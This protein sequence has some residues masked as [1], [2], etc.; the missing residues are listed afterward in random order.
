[1]CENIYLYTMY[2]ATD[3]VIVVKDKITLIIFYK[4]T[5]RINFLKLFIINIITAFISLDTEFL[6]NLK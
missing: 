5:E 4:D 3:A 2:V 1:M 6:N